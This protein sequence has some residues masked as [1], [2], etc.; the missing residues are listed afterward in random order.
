MV[1][2]RK[3]FINRWL[4]WISLGIFGAAFW[5]LFGQPKAPQGD[6]DFYGDLEPVYVAGY[7]GSPEGA[8]LFDGVDDYVRLFP[9][10][11]LPITGTS[12]FTIMMWVQ[13]DGTIDNAD[14]RV[15][16]EPERFDVTRE[17]RRHLGFGHGLHFCIGASLARLE[18][19]VAFEELL[20]AMPD[21]SVE[22]EPMRWASV[23]LR[24]LGALP[25]AFDAQ[26]ARAAIDRQ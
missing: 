3:R 23:F 15:F 11:G 4:T 16:S 10:S 1:T 14:D 18:A 26:R 8:I 13:G 2:R 22:G 20:Q 24:S 6:P 7:D 19:R 17:T 5:I 9:N 25:I 21:Y 12:T